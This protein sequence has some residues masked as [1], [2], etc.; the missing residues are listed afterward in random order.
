M[1]AVWQAL[2]AGGV[3]LSLAAVAPKARLADAATHLAAVRAASGGRELVVSSTRTGAG[4]ADVRHPAWRLTGL[5]RV[6]CR[7]RG[8]QVA[9][10][11]V[12]RARG[13]TVGALACALHR[14]W[15]GQLRGPRVTGPSARFVR[16]QVGVDHA[17][18]DGDA[19]ELLLS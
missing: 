13:A 2:E 5:I 16:Q 12:V 6:F 10:A 19:V 18:S 9:S 17:L 8:G 15:V 14:D 3:D 7:P 1:T 4:L 11:A